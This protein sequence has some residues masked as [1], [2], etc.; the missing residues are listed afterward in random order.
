MAATLT[1]GEVEALTERI[2][3]TKSPYSAKAARRIAERWRGR[4]VAIS[5]YR[6]PLCGEWHVGHVPSMTSVS[7]IAQF[8]RQRAYPPKEPLT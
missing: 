1:P 2:C 6:C 5:P 3:G 7:R 4:G 8:I